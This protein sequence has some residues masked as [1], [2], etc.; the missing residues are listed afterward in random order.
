MGRDATGRLGNRDR[1]GEHVSEQIPRRQ[2]HYRISIWIGFKI[3]ESRPGHERWTIANGGFA[4]IGAPRTSLVLSG[5]ETCAWDRRRSSDQ[6]R[7]TILIALSSVAARA[8]AAAISFSAN[9][10]V[11]NDLISMIPFITGRNAHGVHTSRC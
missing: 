1:G 3:E 7:N 11:I 4:V 6:G 10:C 9:S 5:L 8:K 2:G